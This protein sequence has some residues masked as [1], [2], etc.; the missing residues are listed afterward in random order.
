MSRKP[1]MNAR[2]IQRTT[3][4]ALLVAGGLAHAGPQIVINELDSDT[5]GLD[6]AEFVVKTKARAGAAD[7]FSEFVKVD[8]DMDMWALSAPNLRD[9]TKMRRPVWCGRRWA[10]AD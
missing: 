3:A 8:L 9:T 2:L 4:L 5:D 6:T 7:E 10:E 1:L